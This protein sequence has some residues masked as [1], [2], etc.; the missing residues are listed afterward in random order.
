MSLD[1]GNS[2]LSMRSTITAPQSDYYQVLLQVFFKNHI[3]K[4]AGLTRILP[5][6]WTL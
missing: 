4:D 3:Q 1:K 6:V 2:R 5:V